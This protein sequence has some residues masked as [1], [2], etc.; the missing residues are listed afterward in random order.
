M[1]SA[2]A[3]NRLR[4][5]YLNIKRTPVENI[6]A[7]PQER[8]I[9]E[10]HYVITGTADSPYAGGFYHGKLRFPPEY[11]MKPPAVLMLTPNGRFEVNRRICLSMSDFHPET[12]NPV[13]A[14]ASILTGLYSFMRKPPSETPVSGADAAADAAVT[15]RCTY[16]PLSPSDSFLHF[17]PSFLLD[18]CCFSACTTVTMDLSDWRDRVPFGAFLQPI[19]L[20]LAGGITGDG[21]SQHSDS[22][23]IPPEPPATTESE[24]LSANEHA[25]GAAS[26]GVSAAGA[27]LQAPSTP[28]TPAT[29][30]EN[31]EDELLL[32]PFEGA[33]VQ[34]RGDRMVLN[35]GG[36]VWALD[37]LPQDGARRRRR[38]PAGAAANG[39]RAPDSA[40]LAAAANRSAKKAASDDEDDDEDDEDD[41]APEASA[42]REKRAQ[43]WRFLALSTHPPCEVAADG[44]LVKPTPPDHYFNV[45]EGGA[46]RSLIQ[47]WAIPV[48]ALEDGGAAADERRPTLVYAIDHA[49]GVAWDLQWSPLVREMPKRVRCKRLL[50][51][52]AVCFGDSSV[53]VFDVPEIPPERLSL[54]RLGKPGLVETLQPAIR[55]SVPNVLQLSV[56]WSP[57]RWNLLLTGGS[58]VCLWNLESELNRA[59]EADAAPSLPMEP[60][61]RF[62]DVDTVGKQEAFEWGWGWVA[63]RAVS[64]SPFD[65]FIFATT[66]NIWDIREP[67]LC[68]RSHRIR[69]TWGLSL[70]WMDQTSIQ[71]SGDQGMIFMYDILSGSYQKLYYHPQTDSPVWNIEFARR[72]GDVPLLAS[73]CASGSLRVAPAKR[74][75]RATQHSVELFRLSGERDAGVNKP[76][77]LLTASFDR[78]IVAEPPSPP[79]REF[80]ERDAA[81]HRLRVS[82][83]A[84]GASPCFVA[85]GGHAGLV[86]VLELQEALGNILRDHFLPAS[87]KLGRPRKAED[88]WGS[89]SKAKGKPKKPAVAA[90]AGGK[91][92]A[93][94]SVKLVKSKKMRNALTKYKTAPGAAKKGRK[95]RAGSTGGFIVSDAVEGPSSQLEVSEGEYVDDGE[96]EEEEEDESISSLSLV[97]GEDVSEDDRG[98]IS[99]DDV[100]DEPVARENPERARMMAEYQMDLPE[101]DAIML[102]IQMSEMEQP[103]PKPTTKAREKAKA[104]AKAAPS[105]TAV[106]A[107]TTSVRAIST[108]APGDKKKSVVPSKGKQAA[109]TVAQKKRQT[110]E[111]AGD[112]EVPLAVAAAVKATTEVAA[113]SGVRVALPAAKPVNRGRKAPPTKKAVGKAIGGK[114]TKS[115][116]KYDGYMDQVATLHLIQFQNGM[117][118]EDALVEALRISEAEAKQST[119]AAVEAEAA[120]ASTTTVTEVPAE[121]GGSGIGRL[122][123]KAPPAKPSAVK[124]RSTSTTGMSRPSSAKTPVF[125]DSVPTVR[126]A[127]APAKA[128]AKAVK[129]QPASTAAAKKPKKIPAPKSV[130]RVSAAA[131]SVGSG[132]S[133]VAPTDGRTKDGGETTTGDAAL[134]PV[135]ADTAAQRAAESASLEQPQAAASSSG[136]KRKRPAKPAPARKRATKD[137]KNSTGSGGGSAAGAKGGS[138]QQEASGYLTDEEALYLALRASEVDSSTRPS[139]VVDGTPRPPAMLLALRSLATQ[140][141]ACLHPR[142]KR[143]RRVSDD[144]SPLD[145]DDADPD[146]DD[147]DELD[148]LIDGDTTSSSRELNEL[149][150]GR[151]SVSRGS[152]SERSA[153][154]EAEEASS[155]AAPRLLGLNSGAAL[156]VE[157][158]LDVLRSYQEVTGVVDEGERD[159][160]CVMCLDTF[161]SLNPKVRTLCNCGMNRTNFHMSCLLEWK[162]R[163]AKCPVCREYLYYED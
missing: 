13:W 139:K 133:S 132:E 154:L 61:R 98:A 53:Q 136:A 118:E 64:W 22:S 125:G 20:S 126:A 5:E 4:K 28:H 134:L 121:I 107:T 30:E 27:N 123:L 37:W 38:K 52:L 124:V 110:A 93:A 32:E 152:K 63:V 153:A 1:A 94:A 104:K 60:Q 88:P 35:A 16:K 108:S 12:W 71:I 149:L 137:S 76:Y 69:S 56:Q 122:E 84:A 161:S 128:K 31:E 89:A 54:E 59:D 41:D 74:L 78:K 2:M 58:D 11:P 83:S 21:T 112:A 45:G 23:A 116:G 130:R 99:S 40:A 140:A 143:P 44:K 96:E 131:A 10:W 146:S 91:K 138:A 145:L 141:C 65:E 157:K 150:G 114:G 92:A 155:G 50:G 85:S 120:A 90:A 48:R 57:H 81:L 6:E 18:I 95:P 73:C 15:R 147:G 135:A 144:T 115:A 86:V 70:Q 80:C 79:T 49:S 117:T 163:A 29:R 51:V 24:P 47:V 72:D 34:R 25:A 103:Q 82:A 119:T 159:L 101:E 17:H 142:R 26:D 39:A 67:R 36:P 156:S 151:A 106:S 19:R 68:I 42:A 109:L 87:R 9:L 158:N 129:K 127:T 102:A 97:T 33:C 77:K 111:E 66:G 148:I 43:Q 14:V 8:N 55:A 75:F 105:S 100:E 62:Q 3:T 7:A 46:A 113:A 162:N 160:E